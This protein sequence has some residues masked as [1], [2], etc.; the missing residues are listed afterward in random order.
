MS[1]LRTEDSSEQSNLVQPGKD[2]SL[3]SLSSVGTASLNPN[4]LLPSTPQVRKRVNFTKIKELWR[5][6]SV[7]ICCKDKF[8]VIENF[9]LAVSNSFSQNHRENALYLSLPC[10]CVYLCLLLSPSPHLSLSFP[11]S[12]KINSVTYSVS[13]RVI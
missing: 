6:P 11:C 1:S 10:L 7:N 9:D 8:R 12:S 13:D 4:P 2:G 3:A 5:L